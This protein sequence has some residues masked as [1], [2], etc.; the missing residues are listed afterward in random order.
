M[1]G[2]R[3]VRIDAPWP[4]P[5]NPSE[6]GHLHQ[7]ASFLRRR[8]RLRHPLRNPSRRGIIGVRVADASKRSLQ[9]SSQGILT[10]VTCGRGLIPTESGTR[11]STL[12]RMKLAAAMEPSAS[13]KPPR[14]HLLFLGLACILF[15]LPLLGYMALGS[16][17]RLTGDDYCYAG[18]VT[19]LGFWEAQVYSYANATPYHGNR[20]S[21]TLLSGISSLLGPWTSGLL[22]GLVILLWLIGLATTLRNRGAECGVLPLEALV[23]AEALVFFTLHFAPDLV[24]SLFWRSGMLP[25]LTPLV[26]FPYLLMLI[27]A[28]A[29]QTRPPYGYI[30]AVFFLAFLVGGF[31]ETAAAMQFGLSLLTLVGARFFLRSSRSPKRYAVLLALIAL[32]GTVAAI[33]LLFLSPSNQYRLATLPQPPDLLTLAKMSL[34][35]AYTFLHGT[36][37]NLLLPHLAVFAVFLTMS[38]GA[39]LRH[40]IPAR[41][42]LGR[43]MAALFGILLCSLLLLTCIMAPSA[44]AQS[45]YPELR[46]L[47]GA[48]FISVLAAGIAGWLLGMELARVATRFNR[49]RS[50]S[51]AMAVLVLGLSAYFPYQSLTQSLAALPKYQKWAAFWDARDQA[52]RDSR[53]QGSMDIEVVQLDHI[54]PNVGEL[55]P[56]EDFWYNN[57]AEDYYDV[58]SLRANQPGW[59]D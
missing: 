23:A 38:L 43:T 28:G 20:I 24:Q 2:T 49:L 45:S 9:A 17:M 44:W 32:V 15:A 21:L 27:Y 11:A 54:V 41:P 19:K 29:H 31:S 40:P 53:N 8:R 6:G 30:A 10:R 55:Q 4:D 3:T 26:L 35:S 18:L 52:I 42:N 25:Y 50:V 47:I 14:T 5:V 39:G 56:D 7:A 57:C 36:A 33:L 34:T 48:R 58:R 16:N 1:W 22:P 46:A 37:K 51:A 13:P 12:S 59:D